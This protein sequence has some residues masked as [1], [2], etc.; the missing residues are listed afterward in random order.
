MNY[1]EC[2]NYVTQGDCETNGCTW[3]IDKGNCVLSLCIMDGTGD[4]KVNASDLG[5]YKKEYGRV[6]CALCP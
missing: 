6:D 1:N 2:K 3:R 5:L 4:G